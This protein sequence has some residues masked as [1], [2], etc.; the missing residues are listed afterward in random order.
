[1][2]ATVLVRPL[3]RLVLW[4]VN[5]LDL[6]Q[7]CKH[8]SGV[9]QLKAIQLGTA[10]LLSPQTQRNPVGTMVVQNTLGNR[11]ARLGSDVVDVFSVLVPVDEQ[12]HTVSVRR[13]SAVAKVKVQRDVVA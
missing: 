4:L 9:D 13:G 3:S 2:E 12:L 1:M 6:V 7:G 5:R 8:G 10:F 11:E